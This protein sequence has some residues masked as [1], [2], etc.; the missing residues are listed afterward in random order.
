MFGSLSTSAWVIIVGS[1]VVAAAALYYVFF[2]KKE[3]TEQYV[4]VGPVHGPCLV[5]FHSPKCGACVAFYQEHKKIQDYFHDSSSQIKM[6]DINT[7]VQD[8]RPFQVAATPT[9]RLYPNGFTPEATFFEVAERTSDDVITFVN[10]KMED[11][12]D[13]TE[14]DYTSQGHKTSVW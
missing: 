1:A 2:R 9:L 14:E 4:P 6:V 10:D 13:E 8:Y 3:T 11:L 7:T 5:F 12:Q